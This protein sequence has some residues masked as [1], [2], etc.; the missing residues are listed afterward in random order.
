M[1]NATMFSSVNKRKTC[2]QTSIRREG[3]LFSSKEQV[4]ER[5]QHTPNSGFFLARQGDQSSG[6]SQFE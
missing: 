6:A 5:G 3:H 1:S 2:E 4:I